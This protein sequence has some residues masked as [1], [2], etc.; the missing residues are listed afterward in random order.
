LLE[1]T[2]YWEKIALRISIFLSLRS[3]KD[4]RETA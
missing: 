4:S 2:E 1:L 3:S